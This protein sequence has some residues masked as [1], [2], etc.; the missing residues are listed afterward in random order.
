MR[1]NVVSF[2]LPVGFFAA[3]YL[4]GAIRTVFPPVGLREKL[5]AALGTAFQFCPVQKGGFQF[6][7]KGKYGRDKPAAEKRIADTLH[8]YAAAPVQHNAVAVIVI[9]ALMH[10]AAGGSVLD[11]GEPCVCVQSI[12]YSLL[13]RWFTAA[14]LPLDWKLEAALLHRAELKRC[15]ECGGQFLP[16]SNRG[17]YCP[18]CAGR[19]KRTR[20]A[21]RKRKQRGK[22]HALENTEPP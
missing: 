4:C 12:S 13:C 9:T 16:K 6:P 3:A 10:K 11:N 19:M 7:V 5:T 22:C 14:V 1:R 8:T 18:D 17:K 2:P 15:T 21:Q 20:A